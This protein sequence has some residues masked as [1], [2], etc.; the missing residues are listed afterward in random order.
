[1]QN[2]VTL[3]YSS[4]VASSDLPAVPPAV[5]VRQIAAGA[6][7]PPPSSVPTFDASLPPILVADDDEDD[8]FFVQRLIKKTGVKNKIV[9]FNDGSEVVN[10][11]SRAR[12]GGNG[13]HRRTPLLLFLDLK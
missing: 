9:T 2:A 12:L 3:D 10:Y 8:L 13:F 4:R 6:V 7:V 1:M 11:L 5:G